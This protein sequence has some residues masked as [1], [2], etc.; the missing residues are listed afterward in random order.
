MTIGTKRTGFDSLAVWNAFAVNATPCWAPGPKPTGAPAAGAHSWRGLNC[1]RARPK[2]CPTRC[3]TT[4]ASSFPAATLWAASLRRNNGS[5]QRGAESGTLPRIRLCGPDMQSTKSKTRLESNRLG[6]PCLPLVEG[7]ESLRLQLQGACNVQRIEG[8]NAKR[9][10]K[11]LGQP[12]AALKAF[13]RQPCSLPH[14]CRLIAI[15]GPHRAF[16]FSQNCFLPEDLQKN[17]V[18]KFRAIQRRYP[19]SPPRQ[20]P[21]PCFL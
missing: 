1:H 15:E 6:K 12:H 8:A 11:P 13:S 17:C 2:V 16:C 9:R 5:R 7:P 21:A 14:T 19:N 3:W 4:A 10:S 20:H 18:R